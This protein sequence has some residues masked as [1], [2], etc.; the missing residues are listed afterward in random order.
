M[1]QK[2][3]PKGYKTFFMLDSAELELFL[4]INAEMPTIVGISTFMSM[5]NNS[6]GLFYYEHLKFRAQLSWACKKFYSLRVREWGGNA[7]QRV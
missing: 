2:S 5:N 7:V 1:L 3:R 6:Q 4:L